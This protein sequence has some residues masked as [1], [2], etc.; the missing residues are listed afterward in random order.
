MKNILDEYYA[1]LERLKN[2]VPI[3]VSKNSKITNDSVAL[4]AGRKKGT[5]KKSRPIYSE[6]IEAIK[7]VNIE[8]NKATQ[9]REKKYKTLKENV[10]KYKVLWE[11]S[12]A[13][14]ISLIHENHELKQQ[15]TKFTCKDLNTD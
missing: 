2:E 10:A 1:A 9:Q 12:L 5:I 7:A 15:L 14:E 3:K 6:L 4:E 8:K 11:E 13:R